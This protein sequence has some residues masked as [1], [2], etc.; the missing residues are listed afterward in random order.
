MAGLVI[1]D[2]QLLALTHEQRAHL[3]RRLARLGATAPAAPA[4]T[5]ATVTAQRRRRWLA[6]IAFGACV[7]MIP[8]TVML[9]GNLPDRYV[10]LHWSTTW[11]G[12][13]SL[14]IVS[15]AVTGLLTW[16]HHRARWAAALVTATLLA[17][18]AWFDVSTASTVTDLVGSA[19]TAALGELPLAALLIYLTVRNRE[20]AATAGP[21]SPTAA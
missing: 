5:P 3:A 8:W 12:F 10:T 4:G 14:M 17:C 1:S 11:V 21:P 15:F 19:V 2:A 16:R 7:A 9:A 18:D 13:D 20:P 6:L